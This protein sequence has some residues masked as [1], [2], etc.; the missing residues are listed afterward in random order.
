MAN[1]ISVFHIH[2]VLISFAL[3]ISPSVLYDYLDQKVVISF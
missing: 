2:F 1:L 3:L